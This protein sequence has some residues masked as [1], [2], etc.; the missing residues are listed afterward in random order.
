MKTEISM[1]S[2]VV[3]GKD[4]ISADLGEEAAVLQLKNGIYYGLDPIGARIWDLIRK[5]RKVNQILGCLLE[6][7]QV[8]PDRC[9]QDLLDLLKQLH[10]EGLVEVTN[11]K[12]A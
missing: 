12:T 9:G 7:Y 1:H 4:Q 5:P 6:E 3:A 2:T 10:A 11:E 8:E